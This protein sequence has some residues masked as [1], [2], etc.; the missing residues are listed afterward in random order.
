MDLFCEDQ[1]GRNEYSSEHCQRIFLPNTLFHL[2]LTDQQDGILAGTGDLSLVITAMTN[3]FFPWKNPE[4]NTQKVIPWIQALM[5]A[6]L[7]FVPVVGEILAP[8]RTAISSAVA[9]TA[10]AFAAGGLQTLAADYSPV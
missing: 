3:D 8:E 5:S 6:V 10:G 9:Q 4:T 1:L 2:F 7:S